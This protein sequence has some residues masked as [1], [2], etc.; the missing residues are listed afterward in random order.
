VIDP[1]TGE[2][3]TRARVAATRNGQR[4]RKASAADLGER[5]GIELLGSLPDA[6][7]I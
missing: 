1:R 2:P 7:G 4:A 6:E 3:L 5:D